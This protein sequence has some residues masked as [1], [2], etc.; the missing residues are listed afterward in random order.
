MP[1]GRKYF[2]CF[3]CRSAHFI[4]IFLCQNSHLQKPYEINLMEELT[5]KGVTQYYAYVTERQKV[6]CLNTLFSR[7]SGRAGSKMYQGILP[8]RNTNE[9]ESDGLKK[10]AEQ[11][12]FLVKI[13][14]FTEAK[15]KC[16]LSCTFVQNR[17]C[18]NYQKHTCFACFLGGI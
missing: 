5:L 12:F 7:V 8:F 4:L 15:P 1:E 2:H 14:C 3:A 13:C 18:V 9:T 6:H 11:H 16:F 10:T 17:D